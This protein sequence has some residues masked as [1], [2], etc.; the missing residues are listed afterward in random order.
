MREKRGPRKARL[1]CGERRSRA[2]FEPCRLR[3]GE[4]YDASD[5]EGVNPI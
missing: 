1:L 3:Q 2:V 5:D 4:S